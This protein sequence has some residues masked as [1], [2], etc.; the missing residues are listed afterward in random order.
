MR[1]DPVEVWYPE[2]RFG[3]FT[4]IDGTVLFYARV[5][6]LTGP[7]S[8]VLDVGCGRG[9]HHEDPVQFRKEMRDLRG[10]AGRVIGI[11][12]D[13]MGEKNPFLDEFHV[14]H[15]D[16]R[17]PAETGRCDVLIADSVVEHLQD[18]D[19]FL[20]E[21]SRV[22]RPGGF[23]AIRTTNALGYVAWIAKL[24]PARFHLRLLSRAQTERRPED[25]FLPVYACNTRRQLR[26]ALER[27]GFDSV[28]Y[29]NESEPRYFQFSRVAYAL[30]VLHQRFAPRALKLGLVAFARKRP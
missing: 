15:P 5:R 17:F 27:A 10:R 13:P 11:D 18:P 21:C 20:A 8:V 24:V 19:F 7:S 2:S 6:A 3:G 4:D 1:R 12:V 9:R 16:G 26:K 30:A 23:L 29:T 25:M 22:L 28:V 14:I